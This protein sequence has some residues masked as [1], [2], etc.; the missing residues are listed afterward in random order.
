MSILLVLQWRQ[1]GVQGGAASRASDPDPLVHRNRSAAGRSREC[2][3]RYMDFDIQILPGCR[4]HKVRRLLV[5]LGR[6]CPSHLQMRALLGAW[7]RSHT[8]MC[9]LRCCGALSN[10][11]DT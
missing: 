6:R 9:K 11:D 7:G 2:G 1:R 4:G 5:E 8:R 3:Y 10:G